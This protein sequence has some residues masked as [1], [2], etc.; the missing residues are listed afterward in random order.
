MPFALPNLPYSLDALEPHI[1]A[2]TMLTHHGKHHQAY[3]N[4]LNAAILGTPAD[5][6]LSLEDILSNISAYAPAI[7]NNA[8][9]HYNHTF[10]W[11]ILSPKS[12]ASPTGLLAEDIARTFGGFDDFKK[13]FCSAAMGRFG[14]GWAWLFLD[15]KNKLRICSTANQ[16]NPLMDVVPEE[17]RGIPI[18]GVDVWEHAYY[19]KYKNER[20]RYL[21]A[22]W[23][24]VNWAEVGRRYEGF[25]TE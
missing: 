19:L 14:S 16:D 23:N 9:G 12:S 17:D 20:N 1:D 22:F 2:A 15:K 24:V 10:F 3:V 7:R 13:L 25:K 21:E 6:G 4:N 18:L 5:E 11:E 8:G